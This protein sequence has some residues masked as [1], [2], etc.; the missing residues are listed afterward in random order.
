VLGDQRG[1]QALSLGVRVVEHPSA[2]ALRGGLQLIRFGASTRPTI[3]SF[4]V[5]RAMHAG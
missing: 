4:V 5:L 2:P 1:S 3:T